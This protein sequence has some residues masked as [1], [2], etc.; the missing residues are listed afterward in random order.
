M[1][2]FRLNYSV[3]CV[4]FCGFLFTDCPAQSI[5]EI[6]PTPVAVKDVPAV[7]VPSRPFHFWTP[8]VGGVAFQSADQMSAADHS[9]ANG[10]RTEIER[11]AERAGIVLSRG[12]W[13]VSQVVCP[14]LPGHLFLRYRRLGLAGERTLLSVSIPRGE[15]QIRIFPLVLPARGYFWPAPLETGEIAVFNAIRGEEQGEEKRNWLGTGLCY[16]ALAGAEPVS[17]APSQTPETESPPTLAEPDRDGAVV[18]FTAGGADGKPQ[19]WSLSFD[20]RG[21]LLKVSHI[22]TTPVRLETPQPA[23][24]AGEGKVLREAPVDTK[25]KLLQ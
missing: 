5:R 17:D 7:S 24:P 15:G 23:P 6:A 2:H 8:G 25:G 14:A 10:S 16:A 22:P 4:L 18:R 12:N 19:E 13:M 9:L 20:G 1:R 3:F 21:Q 11:K